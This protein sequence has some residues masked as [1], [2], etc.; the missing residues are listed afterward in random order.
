MLS[1]AG[2]VAAVIRTALE[3][4]GLGVAEHWTVH[5][6]LRRSNVHDE[7]INSLASPNPAARVA[8]ARLC[9]AAHLPDAVMWLADLLADPDRGVREAAV[10][11]LG[12]LG[13]RR[14]V[15]VLESNAT[16][17]PLHLLSVAMAR[18]ASDVDI[19]A[20]MRRPVSEYAAVATVMASG[21]R[22]DVLRIPALL[23][24][25]HDRRWPKNVRLAACKALAMIGNRSA[26]DGLSRVAQG[27][28]DPEVKKVAQR[29]YKRLLK[30]AVARPQ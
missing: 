21:L 10:R 16:R 29:A 13:G 11:A 15:D 8:A 12:R 27:D 17:F 18:A 4:P 5:E 28:P 20:Q 22:R 6:L 26:A 3:R 14:A 7:L 25:A 9:G 1:E 2:P 30:R 19:E 24:I 23:G